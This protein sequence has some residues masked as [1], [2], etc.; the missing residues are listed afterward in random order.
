MIIISIMIMI[1]IIIII[2]IIIIMMG[3][4]MVAEAC[5]SSALGGDSPNGSKSK[6]SLSTDRYDEDAPPPKNFVNF[7]SYMR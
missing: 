4:Q 3:N 5:D 2:F 7:Q 1:S 6:T